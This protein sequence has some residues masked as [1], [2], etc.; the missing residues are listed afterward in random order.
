MYHS[1]KKSS[2][3][4]LSSSLRHDKVQLGRTLLQSESDVQDSSHYLQGLFAPLAYN[5]G[6]AR[7]PDFTTYPTQTS[8]LQLEVTQTANATGNAG[9]TLALNSFATR[10]Y[11]EASGSTDTTISYTSNTGTTSNTWGGNIVGGNTNLSGW[12]S[13]VANYSAIRVAGAAIQVE[14]IGN[15]QN[16]Q[17]QITSAFLTSSDI[18]Y[19]GNT[20]YGFGNQTNIENFRYNYTGAAKNGT[21]IHFLPIDMED[22]KFGEISAGGSIVAH[23]SYRLQ[24]GQKQYGALQWHA[25]GLATG[26][27][28]RVTIRLHLEGLVNYE[29]ADLDTG[30]VCIDSKALELAG[31]IAAQSQAP[32]PAKTISTHSQV[33]TTMKK[34]SKVI[35]QL[36]AGATGAL[37][38]LLCQVINAGS[39]AEC[40]AAAKAAYDIMDALLGDSEESNKKRKRVTGRYWDPSNGGSWRFT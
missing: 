27:S 9:G 1:G 21:Y 24:N 31:Q 30:S 12:A 22:L 13:I 28:F 26:A 23:T 25:S 36:G 18:E 17:G 34:Y 38:A 33:Q 7:V 15:D 2:A 4:N 16:N 11:V 29:Y 39:P 37:T 10:Y 40:A 32:G 35:K 3:R 14:F 19:F 20:T 5:G 8:T 6:Q